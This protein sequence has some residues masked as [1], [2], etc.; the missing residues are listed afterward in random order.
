PNQIGL[1]EKGS[2]LVLSIPNCQVHHPRINQAIAKFLEAFTQ[3]GLTAYDEA[4]H[5][6]DLRYVQCVVERQSLK[7][8]LTLVINRQKDALHALKWRHFAQDLYDSS[9]WHSIWLNFHDT[10]TNAI[11]GRYWEKVIGQEVIWEEIAGNNF[12]FGPSHFGQA[13][14]KMYEEL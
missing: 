12:A 13:N 7:V 2:H 6:G 9:F 1:F 14:L 11:F 5:R 3:S 8:Q 10:R 4:S